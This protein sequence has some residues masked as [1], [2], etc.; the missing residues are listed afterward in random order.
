[1]AAKSKLLPLPCPKC[2]ELYGTM[3]IMIFANDWKENVICRI[4]HY[5][6]EGYKKIKKIYK[7][8]QITKIDK[9][10]DK[11]LEKQRALRKKQ[12]KWCSF[13]IDKE[14]AE[15][16]LPIS[17]DFEYLE[18][19]KFKKSITY[20]SPTLLADIIKNQGWNKLENFSNKYRQGLYFRKKYKS[21]HRSF[22][23]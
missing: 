12:R 2:G 9:I 3:Q 10:N 6:A 1:M 7:I 13:R 21:T 4:G 11:S 5:N 16:I 20:S 8:N 19:N 14:F 18:K 17:E 15:K 23:Y 22:D